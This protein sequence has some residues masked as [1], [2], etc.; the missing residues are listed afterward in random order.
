MWIEYRPCRIT[1]GPDEG[2]ILIKCFTELTRKPCDPL[3]P[4][5]EVIYEG[6]CPVHDNSAKTFQGDYTNKLEKVKAELEKTMAKLEEA[7][8]ELKETVA[9]LEEAKLKEAVAELE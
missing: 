6:D 9:K 3:G 4:I 7:K 2:I 1:T 5:Q 8:A